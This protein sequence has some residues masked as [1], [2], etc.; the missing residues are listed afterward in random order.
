MLDQPYR[1]TPG[2]D[3]TAEQL[4]QAQKEIE[5]LRREANMNA[6]AKFF[7]IVVAITVV[8]L[9]LAFIGTSCVDTI[10][11]Q[12][13]QFQNMMCLFWALFGVCFWIGC[14]AALVSMR[15]KALR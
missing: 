14:G 13:F 6:V 10:A 11:T 4:K 5:I 8:S 7:G 1:P 2:P 3:T 9:L 12:G 15:E